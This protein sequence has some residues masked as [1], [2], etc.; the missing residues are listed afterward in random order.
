MNGLN[1]TVTR[2]LTLNSIAP[3][4]N[5]GEASPD[6]SVDWTKTLFVISP[7][8]K[9]G[10]DQRK[11]SDMMITN[12]IS[13][14]AKQFQLDVVR[15]DKIEE[16]GQIEQQIKKYLFNSCICIADLSY[17]NP[18][19]FYELGI[20][21]TTKL[22]AIQI[23]RKGDDIPFDVSHLRTIIVDVSD[24]YTLSEHFN[25]AR[26]EL[27]QYI[28]HCLS[29]PFYPLTLKVTHNLP[30]K[31]YH[32]FIGREDEFAKLRQRLSATIDS[33]VI[34]IHG[35]GGIGKSTL[36]LEAAYYYLQ[37][38]RALLNDERFT[39]II[40]V[41]AKSIAPI[42]QEIETSQA[43]SQ[44]LEDICN[45]IAEVFG[46]QEL[47]Q[48]TSERQIELV[49]GLLRTQR[50]LLVLDNFQ[51]DADS[52]IFDF[53]SDLPQT[54]RCIV[55]SKQNFGFENSIALHSML[56]NEIQALITQECKREKIN[57]SED[58]ILLLSKGTKGIP[59]AIILTIARLKKAGRKVENELK[60][61]LGKTDHEVIRYCLKESIDYIKDEPA[62]K[63][64]LALS[65]FSS[66]G[67][68]KDIL[69]MITAV[70]NYAINQALELLANL[71]L[72]RSLESGRFEILSLINDEFVNQLDH[73]LLHN[74]KS[75]YVAV[76]YM[77]MNKIVKKNYWGGVTNFRELKKYF[78][79]MRNVERAFEYSIEL[80]NYTH[81]RELCYALVH[82]YA[83]V[84]KLKERKEMVEKAIKA[85]K[86]N[87]NDIALA[88]LCVDAIGWILLYRGSIRSTKHY[89]NLGKQAAIKANL[90]DCVALA[91]GYFARL[92]LRKGQISVATRTI[93]RALSMAESEVI[94]TRLHEIGG[95]I[96]LEKGN[97]RN[98]G[99]HF[100]KILKLTDEVED[101]F[102]KTRGLIE[103]G[104]ISLAK[105][106][107]TKSNVFF[108]DG[109]R[110]ADSE[111]IAMMIALGNFGLATLYSELSKKYNGIDVLLH[112]S[113]RLAY[114]AKNS[115][116]KLGLKGEVKKANKLLKSLSYKTSWS[117]E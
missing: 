110:I 63:V 101:V 47:T 20:R 17:G 11:H 6:E 24:T 73:S 89:V 48:T 50:T 105:G 13:P 113:K 58:E 37:N 8:S 18:N 41:S 111:G 106:E 10:T 67:A 64:L 9:E 27:S 112:E 114:D 116:D 79:E 54:T 43:S 3:E 85:T 104:Y 21:H 52:K 96:E 30:K 60:G 28:K 59:S 39:A 36:A 87:E 40:W 117:N 100:A 44:T 7:I 32:N 25:S 77:E 109:L 65:L 92:A 75:K 35:I 90:L 74:L 29:L 16:P 72:A 69:G 66:Q 31:Y 57:L 80:N 83:Y 108:R 4:Q 56:D 103:L 22:P 55:T 97:L 88:W 42:T 14:V 19:V 34:V 115:F 94:K 70:D 53:L 82:Y 45:T 93:N 33:P 98:A 99:M 2:S 49:I 46:R 1:E 84:G 23:I 68:S 26:A 78:D 107:I 62:Y 12:L 15:S 95:Y 51:I 81:T 61:Y 38:C 71:H 102:L 76:Y 5:L 86:K 91:E